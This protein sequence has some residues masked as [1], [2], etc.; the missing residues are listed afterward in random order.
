MARF[1]DYTSDYEVCDIMEKMLDTF[2]QVFENFDVNMIHFIRTDT[3]K[4]TK[5][6][7]KLRPQSYP[8][9]VYVG[10][11]YI[12]EVM[13][14][15]WDSLDQK[16]KNLAVFH[17]MCAIPPGGFDPG[18]DEYAKKVSPTINMYE[19]EF[20]ASGGVPN[21]EEN[22]SARDPLEADPE[23]VLAGASVNNPDPITEKQPVTNS[24]V[25]GV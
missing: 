13:S 10:R 16:R 8:A 18:S 12:V 6:A 5:E 25:A 2:P 11:P 4:K 7:L 24:T 1:E 15:K 9:E 19:Y 21:W 3:S 17:T 23:K 20:A 14:E 22:E